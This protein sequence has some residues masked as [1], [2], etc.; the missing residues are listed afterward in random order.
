MN[1]TD[2]VQGVFAVGRSPELVAAFHIVAEAAMDGEPKFS[3][4][5]GRDLAKVITC[6]VYA[7]AILELCHLVAIAEAC[8]G[9]PGRY[10]TLFWDTGPARNAGFRAYVKS[11]LTLAARCARPTVRSTRRRSPR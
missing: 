8:D 9:A 5:V 10:E 1:D 11:N 7:P 2:T 6:R 4:A 3:R